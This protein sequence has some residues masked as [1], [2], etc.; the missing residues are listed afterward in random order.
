MASL[1]A[2]IPSIS[3]EDTIVSTTRR[4]GQKEDPKKSTFLKCSK[5]LTPSAPA[6]APASPIP[7]ASQSGATSESNLESVQSF[8]SA[9]SSPALRS[10]NKAENVPDLTFDKAYEANYSL[11]WASSTQKQDVEPSCLPCSPGSDRTFSTLDSD[12]IYNGQTSQPASPGTQS[13]YSTST[14]I[15]ASSF[16]GYTGRDIFYE[17]S[18][19]GSCLQCEILGLRCS[20]NYQKL[21]FE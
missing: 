21:D 10:L 9:H 8:F 11:E 16:V 6:S 19:Q 3:T 18:T 1:T 17:V 5:W 14:S 7:Y 2:T 20:L 4:I 15:S 12:T 13:S